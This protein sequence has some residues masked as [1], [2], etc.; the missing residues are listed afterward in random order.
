MVFFA[1][2]V[3]LLAFGYLIVL[4]R[5]FAIYSLLLWSVVLSF[6][7]SVI[8]KGGPILRIGGVQLDPLGEILPWFIVF[9]GLAKVDF[10][11]LFGIL[12]TQWV[13][14][15]FLS[16]TLMSVGYSPDPSSGLRSWSQLAYP[17]IFYVLVASS[18]HT[19]SQ[20]KAVIRFVLFAGALN[21]VLNMLGLILAPHAM[22]LPSGDTIRFAGTMG[23]DPT[24][25]F[26]FNIFVVALSFYLIYPQILGRN[27]L[28]FLSI[29][30]LGI[31]ALTATR[32]VLVE[33]A[34]TMG[35]ASWLQKKKTLAI[36][37]V[38]A[39]VLALGYSAVPFLDRS[40]SPTDFYDSGLNEFSTGRIGTWQSIGLP[41]YED[42][43]IFGAGL[44]STTLLFE[45][46][47]I[48]KSLH[49][50]YLRM[51]AEGG[52]VGL[53]LFV[54]MIIQLILQSLNAYRLARTDLSRAVSL[55]ALLVFIGFALAASVSDFLTFTSISVYLWLLLALSHRVHMQEAAD[56][57]VVLTGRMK[58]G[59]D[60]YNHSLQYRA[61]ANRI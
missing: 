59:G 17:L 31:Q 26:F 39:A 7:Y 4:P 49:N 5:I 9:G 28:L 12:H 16:F 41:L 35:L 30:L 54:A 53:V 34:I 40:S 56:A 48:T 44:G 38:I 24:A 14:V 13:Y 27:I 45:N 61:G 55:S 32:T 43:P 3:S 25:L 10:R 29:G 21:L 36:M 42:H 2:V 6:V 50:E 57:N 18:V 33:I 23:F 46:V 52:T 60:P 8:T 11:R 22:L 58:V 47:P 37:L 51:G 1:V 20:I 15:L 19:I